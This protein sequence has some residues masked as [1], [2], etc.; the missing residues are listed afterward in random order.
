MEIVESALRFTGYIVEKMLLSVNTDCFERDEQEIS[1]DPNFTRR[2]EKINDNEYFLYLGVSIGSQDV[3]KKMPF[4][5]NVVVR[6][7]FYLTGIEDH[8][9]HIKVNA[10]A[11][12]FPYLRATLSSLMSLANI[13][14][15]F[16]PLVNLVEMFR[17]NEERQSADQESADREDR[18]P[19]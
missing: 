3:E 13:E 14:P 16:I 18:S 5:A 8:I 15:F 11:V 10:V 9:K 4:A 19:D 12:L 1:L 2:I 6:G 7:K 17:Q